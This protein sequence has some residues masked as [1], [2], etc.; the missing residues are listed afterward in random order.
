MISEP[1]LCN[2]QALLLLFFQIP[3]FSTYLS[4]EMASSFSTSTLNT[5]LP[6]TNITNFVSVKLD[7]TNYL[8]WRD[9]VESI[10]ISTDLI[11]H[12]DGSINQPLKTIVTT[13]DTKTYSSPNPTFVAWCKYDHFVKSCITA[14]L[15]EGLAAQT[16]GLSTSK[17]IWDLLHE[18]FL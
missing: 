17:E 8:L 15:S 18:L 16:L 4:L 14:T 13:K 5:P 1:V 12:V 3:L 10:F 2:V 11:G 6:I 7:G 9:Q